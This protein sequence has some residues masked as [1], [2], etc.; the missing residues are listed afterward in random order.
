[1]KR[2]TI[3]LTAASVLALAG[4]VSAEQAL[5]E[6]QM[7]GVTASGSASGY[8]FSSGVG[9]NVFT[10]TLVATSTIGGAPVDPQAGVFYP[11]TAMVDTDALAVANA[12]AGGIF[13]AGRTSGF[14]NGNLFADTASGYIDPNDANTIINPTAGIANQPAL[15][16]S[17]FAANTSAASSVL[18]PATAISSAAAASGM[19]F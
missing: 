18:Y 11:V 9:S 4:A 15:L 3:A 6:A 7:D 14:A 8:A 17:G 5:T 1:M 12:P 19:S 10:S 13:G 16:S 2:I